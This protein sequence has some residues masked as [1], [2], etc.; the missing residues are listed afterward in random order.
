[1]KRRVLITGGLGYVGG[2]AAQ[3]LI[4]DTELDIAVGTRAP[5]APP[6]WLSGADMVQ[7]DW[8]SSKNLIA[9]CT[10]TNTVIHL[11]AM[12]ENDCV[13][14]P[15]GALLA[16][17]VT[18]ARLLQAAIET[19]VQRFV[20]L[21]TAHVYGSLTGLIS[22]KTL[23]R[24][25][26]P[27]A[28]SHRAGEDSVLAAHD[29]NRISGCVIRLSNGFG[30]P[31]HPDVNRWTLIVNDLCR[32]AVQTKKL[33]L[34]SAGLQFRD[35]VTLHDAARAIAHCSKL[36]PEALGDGLFNVGGECTMQVIEMARDI[37]DRCAAVLGYKPEIIYPPAKP[38]E[39]AEMH[40]YSMEK[41][42]ATGF[43]L[44]GNRR[45]EIDATL[46]L[47]AKAFGTPR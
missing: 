24:P 32:Q 43:T 6:P 30:A 3:H 13:A 41:I 12:N 18:T 39:R 40:E 16:N 26:H 47:C 29:A 38:G 42:K 36:P 8:A 9:A 7:T 22:E 37:A 31:A 2:R 11:A 20:Y 10:G 19:G 44:T 34:R 35:F 23:P 17:G 25:Q 27:Y 45:A 46:S 21:S 5:I 15:P 1:M 28:T 4:H 33:A 14:D